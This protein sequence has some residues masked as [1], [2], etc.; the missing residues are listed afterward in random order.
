M[1]Q[2]MSKAQTYFDFGEDVKFGVVFEA[3][4]IAELVICF[5][6]F[7]SLLHR[8]VKRCNTGQIDRAETS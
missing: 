7:R 2:L 8:Q 6:L 5:C 4:F 3:G 1:M